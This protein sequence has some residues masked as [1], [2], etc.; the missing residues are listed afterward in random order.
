MTKWRNKIQIKQY[1]TNDSSDESVS[2]IANKIIPQIKRVY[3]RESKNIE[4]VKEG[5]YKENLE[6]YLED[7]ERL[8]EEFTWIS[9]TINDGIAATEFDFND[10]CEVLNEYLG[11]LYDLGDSVVEYNSHFD[12][13]KYLWVG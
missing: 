2:M 10:W 1:L 5:D 7:L 13:E 8:L 9:D 6:Y 11:Q 4:R 3:N 12:Q